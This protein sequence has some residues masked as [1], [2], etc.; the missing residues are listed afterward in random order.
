MRNLKNE[1]ECPLC[2]NSKAPKI[3]T[4][5]ACL[6]FNKKVGRRLFPSY[7]RTVFYKDVLG[8][9]P[10]FQCVQ[11]GDC[12]F[13]WVNPRTTDQGQEKLHEYYVERGDIRNYY[14]DMGVPYACSKAKVMREYIGK[15][16]ADKVLDFGGAW[17]YA[18]VP[19]MDNGS[20][21]HLWDAEDWVNWR[22][23]RIKFTQGYSP[24]INDSFDLVILSHVLEHIPGLVEFCERIHNLIVDGGHLY[25]E[26]P[27]IDREWA[28]IKDPVMHINFFNPCNLKRL[29]EFC[30]LG[31]EKLDTATVP[32]LENKSIRV[33]RG[34]FRKGK[35]AI[36]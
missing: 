2:G 18:L 15:V 35:Y 3:L 25:V 20:E 6:K 4:S 34:L 19:F 5:K 7:G 28:K 17:G 14:N 1:S 33:I 23:K 8:G 10:V 21:G 30:G 31:A 29:I 32:D 9:S 36:S 12:E 27:F 13:I 16:C 11:C 22:D 26:V 24:V